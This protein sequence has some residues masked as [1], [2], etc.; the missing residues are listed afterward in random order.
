MRWN[1]AAS[2]YILTT[3]ENSFFGPK[4]SFDIPCSTVRIGFLPEERL[5]GCRPHDSQTLRL[6]QSH[7]APTWREEGLGVSVF[8]RGWGPSSGLLIDFLILLPIVYC[9][10]MCFKS[11]MT[12]WQCALNDANCLKVKPWHFATSHD[13]RERQAIPVFGRWY[14][15]DGFFHS[16]TVLLKAVAR[17]WIWEVILT[18]ACGR[19]DA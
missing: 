5:F 18:L 13:P 16:Q 8:P 9:P 19:G 3:Y 12:L 1:A 6:L 14:D 17:F 11:F 15:L 10:K 7:Q 2:A 4:S